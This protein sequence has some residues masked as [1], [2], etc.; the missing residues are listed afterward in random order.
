MVQVGF[1]VFGLGAM[2]AYIY[3]SIQFHLEK[4]LGIAL[5]LCDLLFPAHPCSSIMVLAI[6]GGWLCLQGA[7][8]EDRTVVRVLPF[9]PQPAQSRRQIANSLRSAKDNFQPQHPGPIWWVRLSGFAPRD[10]VWS[11]FGSHVLILDRR[12]V[13][14]ISCR[15]SHARF[16]S[17]IVI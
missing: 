5:L 11:C 6:T 16:R 9:L 8:Q 17:G 1:K 10:N 14:Q 2:C 7:N 12:S 3:G 13:G 15:P 4:L